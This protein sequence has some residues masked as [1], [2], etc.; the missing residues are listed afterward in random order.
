LQTARLPA[1]Q[2]KDEAMKL[3]DRLDA[4][5]QRRFIGEEN[6]RFGIDTEPLENWQRIASEFR[7]KEEGL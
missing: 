2:S 5:S 1:L 7:A 3:L 6:S 4:A